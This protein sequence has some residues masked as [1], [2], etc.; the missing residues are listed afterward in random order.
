MKAVRV[1]EFGGPEV[2]SVEDIEAP[3]AAEGEALIK[4]EAAGINFIDTYQRSGLYQI[5]LPS[6]LGLE[7]AGTVEAVGPGVNRFKVGDRVAYTNV[8]GAYADYAAVPEDKLVSLPEGVSFAQGAAA[9]LQGCTAHY[10]CQSTYKVKAGDRCLVHAAA[11]GVGLL[12]IQMIKMLGGTVIGTCSTEAKAELAR[13]AGADE[14]ILYSDQ[15]FEAEVKRIT[16]GEGVNVVY[17]SV[18]KATFEKSIDCLSRFGYMVLYGNASGPV[19]E[20]NPATLGP[21][22]SLFLTRPTLFDYLASREDLDWRSGDLFNWIAEGKLNLRLEHFFPLAEA[23]AAHEALEGRKT[24]GKVI[25][26]P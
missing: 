24:T 20:F 11:G 14:V 1:N 15:D 26:T 19:T 16:A 2:L 10:L 6:T 12:L 25:L 4:V 7:A 5:P 8:A 17:D 13:Q 22:G 18:G 23:R 9:M 21:K 3:V